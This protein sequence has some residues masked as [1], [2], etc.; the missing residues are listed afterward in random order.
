M[1]RTNP[2][3][4]AIAR[5]VGGQMR[6]GRR[7]RGGSD[8][9]RIFLRRSGIGLAAT[10]LI[11]AV[12]ACV[13]ISRSFAASTSFA[14]T[15]VE[16][17]GLRLLSGEQIL[18]AGGIREGDN[19]FQVD[20]RAIREQVESLPWVKRALVMRKPPNRVVIS[21]VERRRLAWI[22]LGGLSER[23][24]LGMFGVDEEGWLLP[25]PENG[26]SHQDLDLPVIRGI[27][28]AA[29]SLTV[30]AFVEDEDLFQL[31]SWWREAKV[32]DPEFCLN[33]SEIELIGRPPGDSSPEGTTQTQVWSG[34][35]IRLRLVGD[36]LEVRLPAD[37]VSQ[38]LIELKAVLGRIYLEYTEPAY[39]D[40]R[41]AGQAVIGTRETVGRS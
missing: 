18:K 5:S 2:G 40:L 22:D 32:A 13:Q 29:D 1:R 21:V 4:Q 34:R 25:S 20:L 24:Y 19:V 11:A 26:E 30:G 15:A 27:Q 14:L 8:R 3:R 16:V 23:G 37:R 39:V 38:R 7:Q 35:D 28:T 17:R 9:L 36:G 41:F 10:I 6:R 31:V 12:C 33:V